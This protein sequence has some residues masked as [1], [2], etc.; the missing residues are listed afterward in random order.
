VQEALVANHVATTHAEI[1]LVPKT[2]V[3]VSDAETA[4]KVIRLVEALDDHDDVQ[5]VYSNLA[6]NDQVMAAIEKG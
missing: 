1:S 6:M 2:T 4:V 5:N 3:D